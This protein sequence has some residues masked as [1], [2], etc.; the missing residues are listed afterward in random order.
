V[1]LVFFGIIN[2]FTIP[3]YFQFHTL[4]VLSVIK[5]CMTF[6]SQWVISIHTVNLQSVLTLI[7]L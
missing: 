4:K 5:P 6:S 7:H 1:V 3:V 2:I